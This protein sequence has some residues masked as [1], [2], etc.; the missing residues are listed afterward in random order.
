MVEN[1]DS[2]AVNIKQELQSLG[3]GEMWDELFLDVR[4]DNEII[5]KILLK[6]IYLQSYQPRINVY[7]INI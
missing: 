4:S 3:L 5:E 7:Y 6:K 2:W 1:N